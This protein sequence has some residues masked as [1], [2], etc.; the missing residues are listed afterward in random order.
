MNKKV[1]QFFPKSLDGKEKVTNLRDML[2]E[3]NEFYVN[4]GKSCRQNA[5][6]K[7]KSCRISGKCI[8]DSAFFA[9]ITKDEIVT[10]LQSLKADK[11]FEYDLI[12]PRLCKDAM[13]YIVSPL[14][15]LCNV[16]V[17]NE[18]SQRT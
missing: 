1:N 9:P 11:V 5:S 17:M 4:I 16:S 15:Y 8:Q 10:I 18:S 2:E 6:Y 14:A 3:F 7:H 12:H 13:P